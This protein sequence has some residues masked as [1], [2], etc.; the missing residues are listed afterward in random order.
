M[1]E[2]SL[3]IRNKE[4]K[5]LEGSSGTDFVSLVY[6]AEYQDG[7]SIV[8]ETSEKNLHIVLQLDDALGTSFCYAT[9]N[10]YYLIPFGEKRISY[11]PKAFYGNCHYLYAR[12]ATEEEIKNYRNLALNINDQHGDTHCYPH[13]SANVETR[14]ESVFAARNAIDGV[15]ANQSHGAW[16][17]E[18]W[19]I[20][21]NPDAEMTVDFGRKVEVDKVVLV[22][23][24]DF[25]H[26]SWWTQVTLEFS[27]GSCLD[28]K[29]EKSVQPHTLTFEKKRISWVK[30]C[31]LIKA[32][33][34]SP[35]PALT[36]M[37]VYGRDI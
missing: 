23:R 15:C 6:A 10:V 2:L 26:D 11:S 20:N 14:G 13:A 31:K 36:Q 8:F 16:P 32:E 35:F 37:E 18:S 9:D 12:V 19:G 21:R 25:P 29:L 22:T 30:L 33:D 5:I 17:Y 24:A 27:D 3:K 28:W 7:D 34:E 1:A 4:G